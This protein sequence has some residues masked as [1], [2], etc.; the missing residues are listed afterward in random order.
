MGGSSVVYYWV[1]EARSS[2]AA[3]YLWHWSLAG[4]IFVCGCHLCTWL[5]RTGCDVG[6]I[7]SSGRWVVW[8]TVIINMVDVNT[9]K[10]RE[11]VF[12]SL[13]CGTVRSW[14]VMTI[15]HSQFSVWH[16]DTSSQLKWYA[17]QT[18]K[19]A[20]LSRKWLKVSSGGLTSGTKSYRHSRIGV[21]LLRKES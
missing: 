6:T 13:G 16:R 7:S 12:R 11:V 8:Y 1:W 2:R 9:D 10:Y 17:W 14:T 15:W 21:R 3:C 18:I 5:R 19:P 4:A 20:L